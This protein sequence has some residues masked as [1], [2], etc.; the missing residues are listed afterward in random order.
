MKMQ[1]FDFRVY[2]KKYNKYAKKVY[3][4]LNNEVLFRDE[5]GFLETFEDFACFEKSANDE[6]VLELWTGFVDS[7]NIK[8]FEGDILAF[9][10]KEPKS[11][12]KVFYERG[13]F[14][15]DNDWDKVMPIELL[16][17]SEYYT[18]VGNIHE[19]PELLESLENCES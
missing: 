3:I 2:I 12:Y 19:N 8:I 6:L 11:L 9:G 13:S 18:I 15:L 10:K 17:N 1:D 4:G 7:K 16:K 14:R 5:A